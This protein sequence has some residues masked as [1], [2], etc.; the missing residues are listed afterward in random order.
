MHKHL[1]FV[2]G[3]L[4]A[5]SWYHEAYLCGAELLG[6]ARTVD[7]HAMYFSYVPYVY[8]NEPVSRIR[9]E[10]YAVAGP[11]LARLDE[12]ED[13][14]TVYRR[15]EVEVELDNGKRVQAWMYFYPERPGRLIP[16]GDFFD[17]GEEARRPMAK[18]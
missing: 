4:R 11:R 3:S 8:K 5:G 2:Y 15:E 9:G 1:V 14:P 16:S 13:H 6:R 18:P 12:L 17:L 7:K 10:V